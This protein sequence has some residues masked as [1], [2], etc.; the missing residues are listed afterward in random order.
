MRRFAFSLLPVGFVLSLGFAHA[1]GQ[2]TEAISRALEERLG[3]ALAVCAPTPGTFMKVRLYAKAGQNGGKLDC[4]N[5][6]YGLSERNGRLTSRWTVERGTHTARSYAIDGVGSVRFYADRESKTV[7]R[8]ITS[9]GSARGDRD[10]D[11]ASVILCPGIAFFTG[12]SNAGASHVEEL[13]QPAP[14]ASYC[15][16]LP[17]AWSKAAS[18]RINNAIKRLT[19]YA[20]AGCKGERGGPY[21]GGSNASSAIAGIALTLRAGKRIASFRMEF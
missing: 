8:A 20:E 19:L 3:N 18:L 4:P 11:W 12:T 6:A 10:L 14:S 5:H 16:T 13:C 9:D 1:A 2:D 15:L 7:M 17:E 21:G